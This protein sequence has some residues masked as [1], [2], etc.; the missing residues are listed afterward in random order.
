M[1]PVLALHMATRPGTG[2]IGGIVTR[3]A[4][5]DII[6][7]GISMTVSPTQRRVVE[8]HPVLAQMALVAER[9]DLMA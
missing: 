4:V 9:L 6:A 3:C 7:S 8:R 5:L 2:R 1:D